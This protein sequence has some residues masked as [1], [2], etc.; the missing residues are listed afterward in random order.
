MQRGLSLMRKFR[1]KMFRHFHKSPRA[2]REKKRFAFSSSFA[3]LAMLTIAGGNGENSSIDVVEL[4]LV[5][6]IRGV[7]ELF[8]EML[9]FFRDLIKRSGGKIYCESPTNDPNSCFI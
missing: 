5:A 6:E 4:A 2:R 1:R 3:L 9:V 8:V 7:L